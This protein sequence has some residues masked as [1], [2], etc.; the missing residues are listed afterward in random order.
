MGENSFYVR[1]RLT[2]KGGWGELL[3]VHVRHLVLEGHF[4]FPFA[5]IHAE[6]QLNEPPLLPFWFTPAQFLGNIVIKKD[7]THVESF[8]LAVPNNKSLNVGEYY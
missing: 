7:G 4:D 2:C 6:F 1:G 3:M 5:R 8:H